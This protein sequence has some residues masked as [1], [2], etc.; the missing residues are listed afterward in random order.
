[1]VG[2]LAGVALCAGCAV[3]VDVDDLPSTFVGTYTWTAAGS[4][5]RPNPVTLTIEHATRRLDGTIVFEGAHV[6]ASGLRTRVHGRLN[7]RSLA[8]VLTE[9]EPSRTAVTDG[10]FEGRFAPDLR[11]LVAIWTTAS[12]GQLGALVLEAPAGTE[13]RSR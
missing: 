13:V 4:C 2:V 7:A 11:S 5:E 9:S 12:T 6:Y 8:V 10:A 3:R 1:M